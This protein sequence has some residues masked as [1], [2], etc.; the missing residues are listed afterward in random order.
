MLKDTYID[1]IKDSRHVKIAGWV[2]EVRDIGNLVFV[3]I[4]DSTGLIQ[5][6]AKKGETS[7]ELMNKLRKLNKESAVSVEGK[8]F[9]S[10]IAKLKFEL[11][12]SKVEIVAQAK[13]PLPLETTGKIE[14]DL[15]TRLDNRF[16]DLRRSDVQAI[17]RIQAEIMHSFRETLK[18]LDF[19]EINPPSLISAASEG[20]TD[21]FCL[22]YFNQKAFLAQS[23]QLYKQMSVVGGLERVF[24]ITP[25]W[26]AERSHTTKHMTESRQMDIEI[27]FADD[28]DALEYYD[29]VIKKIFEDV[30]KNCRKELELL[31]VGLKIPKVPLR[32]LTYTKA[33]DML[34]AKKII[35]K[36]GND[37][38]PEAEME[39][40]KIIGWDEPAIITE[41][42][43]N[44][45]AFY[46]LPFSDEP[47]MCKAYDLLYH[48]IEISSGAQR[49]HAP[50]LLE[51]R[52]KENKLNPKNFKDYLN[53]L[54]YGAP[55][56]AGWSIGLERL[57]MSILNLKNIREAT[58]FPRDTNRLTP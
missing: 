50:E 8:A 7:G 16:L 49:V 51:K 56:H 53:S 20:G 36:W 34:K 28:K 47:K 40:C 38:S 24:M 26:R 5:I 39:I 30:G 4:R 42:P 35:I 25:V 13:A 54:R 58:L 23:P 44:V 41:W 6:T 48:G 45:R 37:L 33:L 32:R 17:I 46:S 55:P 22:P 14:S 9:K 1:G 31:K 11:M 12:P 2:H 52:L 57:T 29:K 10:K 21:M 3:V 43:T 27:A 15:E 19:I 18:R